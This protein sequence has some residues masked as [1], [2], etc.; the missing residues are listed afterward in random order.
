M[1]LLV[2][3]HHIHHTHHT[4]QIHIPVQEVVQEVE[5][6]VD[7]DTVIVPPVL[8]QATVHYRVVMVTVIQIPVLHQQ[9]AVVQENPVK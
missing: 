1:T 7:M 3:H 9:Q 6:A 4:H 8:Y 5:V 2:L